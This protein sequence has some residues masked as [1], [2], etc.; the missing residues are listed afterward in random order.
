MAS[1]MMLSAQLSSQTNKTFMVLVAPEPVPRRACN[2]L[3]GARSAAATTF[4]RVIRGL[5][6][7][8]EQ[9][10]DNPQGYPHFLWITW[11]QFGN[12]CASALG[13]HMKKKFAGSLAL[14]A[15]LFVASCATRVDEGLS[16]I[17][18]VE[19]IYAENRSFDHL[20]GLFP[21]AD[22]IANA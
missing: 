20:Y 6:T 4:S 17:E 5:R 21:G 9:S 14:F 2:H 1:A 7:R 22:G 18:H 12:V 8:M 16:R 11:R 19:V 10:H 3:S 13:R 15:A